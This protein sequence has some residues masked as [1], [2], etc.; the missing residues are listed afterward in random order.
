MP[1]TVATVAA[2]PKNRTF[3]KDLRPHSGSQNGVIS[4]A[5]DDPTV[6]LLPLPFF[7]L[8]LKI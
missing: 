8:N 1:S 6:A 5:L 4:T 7:L 2:V 3:E